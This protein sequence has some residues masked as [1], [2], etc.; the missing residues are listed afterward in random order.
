MNWIGQKTTLL[1]S[2]AHTTERMNAE[3]ALYFR[4]RFRE[5]REA[6]QRDAENFGP[7]VFALERL[8]AFLKGGRGSGMWA[9]KKHLVE[10]AHKSPLAKIGESHRSYHVPFPILF[11]LVRRERNSAMH[12]GVFARHLTQHAIQMSIILE[13]ALAQYIPMD[14]ISNFMVRNPVCAET[15]QPLSFLRQSMLANSFSCL[16]VKL[17]KEGRWG[18]VTDLAIAGY[19]KNEDREKRLAQP[20]DEAIKGRLVVPD[21]HTISEDMAVKEV[22]AKM[23]QKPSGHVL[24][25]TDPSNG[26]LLGIVTPFD[27]L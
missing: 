3:A 23:T 5:A 19:L 26:H 1:A 4:E 13:D 10:L 12:E 7:I 15:W 8:G 22:L 11:E 18:L 16:P 9:L 20:L 21:A 6:A 2:E 14:H 24:L 25:V 27:L 17:D